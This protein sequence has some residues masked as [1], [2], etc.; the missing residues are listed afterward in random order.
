MD[1]HSPAQRSFNMSR[2]RGRDTRPEMLV[3]RGLHGRGLRYRLHDRKLPG[4]PDLVFPA[5][6]AVI[7][8]HGCFW[9]GHDCPLFK[10]PATRTAFWT[11]KIEGN[12]RRDQRDLGALGASGWR[13]LLIWECALRGRGRLPAEE[14]IDKTTAWLRHGTGPAEIGGCFAVDWVCKGP[15]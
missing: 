9:H 15:L 12:R 2:V 7:F 11:E 10:L 4:R 3:R 8:V 14:V 1:V 5:R 13:T 6:R